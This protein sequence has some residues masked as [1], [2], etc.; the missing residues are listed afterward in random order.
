MPKTNNGRDYIAETIGG[1]NVGRTQAAAAAVTYAATSVTDTGAAFSSSTGTPGTPGT[2]SGL[3]GRVV[4]AG[5]IAAGAAPVAYGTIINN[6]ATVLTID[7]W[8]TITAP[9]TVATTPTSGGSGNPYA[10][11]PAGPPAFFMGLSVA[12]RADAG[13]NPGDAFLTNDGSTVSEVFGAAQA[14]L[15]RQIA[16]YAHTSGTSTYTISNTFTGTGSDSY[17]A[18]IAKVGVF[19]TGVTAAPTTTTTGILLW[20]TNLSATATLNAT[21]DNVQIT[22]TITIS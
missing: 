20:N 11:L 17:P 16:A 21:G 19:V 14:G 15:S 8:H 2:G 9:Q 12:T 10:V 1:R 6:T 5:G 3:V 13:T 7:F 22:D 4:V 18:A